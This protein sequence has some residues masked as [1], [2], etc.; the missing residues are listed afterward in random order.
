MKKCAI[1][2]K[3]G[4]R[5][6]VT[7]YEEDEAKKLD[8]LTAITQATV[9][10]DSLGHELNLHREDIDH[11]ECDGKRLPFDNGRMVILLMMDKVTDRAYTCLD[12][13]MV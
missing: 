11:I 9:E 6:A 4:L 1:V 3:S 12:T 10:T 5:R 8:C 7:L 13:L 2:Y